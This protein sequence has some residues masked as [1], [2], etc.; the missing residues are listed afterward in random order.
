MSSYFDNAQRLARRSYEDLLEAEEQVYKD[1]CYITGD[2]EFPHDLREG[3]L[4][5][6]AVYFAWHLKG[7]PASR[8][9]IKRARMMGCSH[10]IERVHELFHD[11]A[12]R[13]VET[14]F[15]IL[16]DS[17]T[18]MSKLRDEHDEN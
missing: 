10:G 16:C 11:L 4:G 17:P 13:R 9:A 14:R 8:N 15:G 3:I 18:Q 7:V 6:M 12:R 2:R 1:V 5:T